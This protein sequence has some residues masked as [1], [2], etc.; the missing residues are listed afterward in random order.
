MC[1]FLFNTEKNH[2]QEAVKLAASLRLKACLILI[3]YNNHN[4]HNSSMR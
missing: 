3:V 4:M 1:F 2:Y